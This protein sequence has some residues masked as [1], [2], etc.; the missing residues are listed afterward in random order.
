MGYAAPSQGHDANQNSTTSPTPTD[1]SPHPTEGCFSRPCWWLGTPSGIKPKLNHQEQP[2]PRSP[3]KATTSLGVHSHPC[4]YPS[5]E[6]SQ[7]LKVRN[8]TRHP[9]SSPNAHTPPASPDQGALDPATLSSPQRWRECA[10]WRSPA[11]VGPSIHVGLRQKTSG[12]LTK[13]KLEDVVED[14]P[15]AARVLAE[16]ERLRVGERARLVVDLVGGGENNP[17]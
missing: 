5:L 16:L 3:Q 17:R 9:K 1:S 13:D 10:S 7:R 14:E 15:L 12:A 8:E 6:P 2:P 11:Q 4:P